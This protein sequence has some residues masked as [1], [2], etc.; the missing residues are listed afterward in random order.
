LP[1]ELPANPL[2]SGLSTRAALLG[3]GR[4][5]R[6]AQGALNAGDPQGFAIEARPAN[7]RQTAINV[8]SGQTSEGSRWWAK[9][10]TGRPRRADGISRKVNASAVAST[11][12]FR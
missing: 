12:A 2:R 11:G 8:F 9:V 1:A 6:C 10:P 3:I 5:Q 4:L 7:Q